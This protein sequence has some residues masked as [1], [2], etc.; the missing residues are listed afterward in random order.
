[1]ISLCSYMSLKRGVH[2]TRQRIER[3]PRAV[4]LKQN[5]V[6]RFFASCPDNA[7]QK[8][9]SGYAP[10][11]PQQRVGAILRRAPPDIFI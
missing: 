6:S 3:R 4:G 5:A 2:T 1:M 8:V 11:S 7:F 10:F 9:P